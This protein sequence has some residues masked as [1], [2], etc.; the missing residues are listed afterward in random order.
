MFVFV[1]GLCVLAKELPRV[2]EQLSDRREAG[3]VALRQDLVN[4]SAGFDAG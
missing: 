4:D 2:Y 3:P 1:T